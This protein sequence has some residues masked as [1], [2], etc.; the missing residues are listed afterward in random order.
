MFAPNIGNGLLPTRP[1]N[2]SLAT[3]HRGLEIVFCNGVENSF[4]GSIKDWVG[5]FPDTWVARQPLPF[6]GTVLAN[7]ELKVVMPLDHPIV[8]DFH[9]KTFDQ[10]NAEYLG[11]LKRA[12]QAQ[13]GF[14]DCS[15][16]M[17]R[18]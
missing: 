13:G 8:A 4:V 16:C 15:S 1:L 3:Q 18:R 6:T 12:E 11:V 9:S 5:A 2:V 10:N 7:G 14:H 17:T